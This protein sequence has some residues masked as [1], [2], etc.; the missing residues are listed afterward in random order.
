MGDALSHG[1]N[2]ESLGVSLLL[3]PFNRIVVAGLSLAPMTCPASQGSK[4]GK[5]SRLRINTKFAK[6]TLIFWREKK[7]TVL[8]ENEH[9]KANVIRAA[10]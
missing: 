1:Y 10:L 6:T 5:E 4:S 9:S 7:N 2:D 3:Y 8:V